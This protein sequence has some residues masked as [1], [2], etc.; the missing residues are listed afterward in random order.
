MQLGTHARLRGGAL[1]VGLA[2]GIAPPQRKPPPPHGEE[3]GGEHQRRECARAAAEEGG[4]HLQGGMGSGGIG[5]GIGGIGLGIGLHRQ[6]GATLLGQ[7]DPQLLP[8]R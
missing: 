1:A 4:A 7:V 2:V 8:G 5:L 3:A 6:V